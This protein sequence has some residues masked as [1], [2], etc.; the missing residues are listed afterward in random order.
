MQA[1]AL[2][3]LLYTSGLPNVLASMPRTEG[4]EL[5]DFGLTSTSLGPADSGTLGIRSFGSSS[6][7]SAADPGFDQELQ[8]LWAMLD[9][10]EHR[11]ALAQQ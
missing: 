1:T 8:E 5:Q 9:P 11:E 10:S 2:S 3:T 6:E 7:R 4:V